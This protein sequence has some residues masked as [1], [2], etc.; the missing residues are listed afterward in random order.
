MQNQKLFFVGLALLLAC[1]NIPHHGTSLPESIEDKLPRDSFVFLLVKETFGGSC[2]MGVCVSKPKTSVFSGSGFVVSNTATGSI[3]ATAA[4]VCMA[5]DPRAEM[6]YSITDI[7]GKSYEGKLLKTQVKGDM[8]VLYVKNLYK[9]ALKVANRAPRPGDKV[10]NI[11]APL[12]IF[13]AQMVPIL[14]GRYNGLGPKGRAIY[15]LPAA[16]GSSGSMILNSNF[17]VIGMLT[18]VQTQFRTITIG[19]SYKGLK[20]FLRENINKFSVL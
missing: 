16:G 14:E 8:C 10:Y 7:D 9:P 20:K 17:E 13:N 1:A 3:I 4:H 15:S 11:A 12:G 5:E 2:L 19:P 6:E 18:A